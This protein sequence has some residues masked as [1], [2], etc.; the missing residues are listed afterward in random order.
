MAARASAHISRCKDR[1]MHFIYQTKRD[2]ISV[3]VFFATMYLFFT[4][5]RITYPHSDIFGRLSV[6]STTS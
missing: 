5:K 2:T 3:K 4:G 1:H 6:I